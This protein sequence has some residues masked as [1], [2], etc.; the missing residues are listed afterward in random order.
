MQ[1]KVFCIGFHKTGTT[2]LGAALELLGY[3]VSGAFGVNKADVEKTALK[4]ALALAN[5]HDAFQDNPWPILYRELDAAF[6][7]S[8]FILTLRDESQW[9]QSLL[10]HFAGKDTPM[11]RWI[12]GVGDPQGNESI[13][14]QRYKRHNAEV[15]DYFKNRSDDLLIM[16]L[17]SGDG[18]DKLCP[19][20]GKTQPAT[21]FPHANQ[22]TIREQS[23]SRKPSG[24]GPKLKRLFTR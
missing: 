6:P 15:L 2:S 12:Y 24:L 13:Y 20:L 19:F 4:K 3:K 1:T 21:P 11:R 17:A 16:N 22:A 5:K 8:R 14:L 18:W 23:K 10:K 7:G 9:L